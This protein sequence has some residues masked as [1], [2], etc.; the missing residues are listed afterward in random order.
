ME[1]P[2]AETATRTDGLP[3]L[4]TVE[5]KWL[6][7]P[8]D[9][10]VPEGLKDFQQAWFINLIRA[11][12][13]SENTGYLVLCKEGCSGCPACLWRAANAHHP[14]HFKKHSSLVLACFSSA[15]IAGR[16]V[17]YFPKLVG[18]IKDQLSKMRKHRSR[19]V[20]LSETYTGFNRGGGNC[21]LSSSLS[22]D[23][24]LDSKEQENKQTASNTCEGLPVMQEKQDSR[25]TVERED[26]EII[27]TAQRVVRI[28]KL[29]DASMAAAIA[30]VEET[31]RGT[32]LSMDGIVQEICTKANY[33]YRKKVEGHEF[34]E[35]FLAQANARKILEALNLPINDNLVA[36][37][38]AVV[39]AETKDTGLSVEGAT[40]RIIQAANED[41][42]RGARI[43]IFYLED[44]KWR[45]NARIGKAEQRKLDN[46]EA[47]AQV[48]RRLREKFGKP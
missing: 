47:N 30:A 29:T 28:L 11:S 15:Q 33:A 14:E 46:L 21:S 12:L 20:A 43:D 19:G 16:R 41:R 42:R 44:V 39:K 22:F 48:K 10:W 35:H 13:R 40:S 26:M 9:L 45:S 4:G 17:L 3:P 32:R 23:F 7:I 31:S 18:V 8:P 25:P 36:R 1:I 6:P 2:G 24:D 27:D 37:T 5:F 38:A 34:L